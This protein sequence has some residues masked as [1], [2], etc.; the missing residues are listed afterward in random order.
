V[1]INATAAEIDKKA[2]EVSERAV[3][4]LEKN[5][6]LERDNA[7]MLG[8]WHDVLSRAGAVPERWEAIIPP[9]QHRVTPPPEFRSPHNR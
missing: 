4:L 3:R 1:R 8:Q 5:E 2:T 6:E 9:H 7:E